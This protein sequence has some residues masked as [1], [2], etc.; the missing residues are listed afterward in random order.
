MLLPIP[1][2]R[3]RSPRQTERLNSLTKPRSLLAPLPSS[4]LLDKQSPLPIFFLPERTSGRQRGRLSTSSHR[5]PSGVAKSNSAG[6]PNRGAPF[7]QPLVKT[8]LWLSGRRPTDRPKAD[9]FE[10]HQDG[11]RVTAPNGAAADRPSFKGHLQSRAR[12][13]CRLQSALPPSSL[14]LSLTHRMCMSA[15]QQSVRVRRSRRGLDDIRSSTRVTPSGLWHYRD[16]LC[17]T[18]FWKARNSFGCT[19]GAVAVGNILHRF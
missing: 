7:P 6:V 1:R 11:E 19:C 14:P 8:S 12:R 10:T 18:E 17:C 13:R 4:S 9:A 16:L 2:A 3:I 5:G 15:P